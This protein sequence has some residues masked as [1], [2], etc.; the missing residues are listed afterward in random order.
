MKPNPDY[1]RQLHSLLKPAC[2][3]AYPPCDGSLVM[4]LIRGILS[5][6]TSDRNRDM[7]F[8][9]LK[10]AYPTPQKLVQATAE[11]IEKLIS[12]AGLAPTKSRRIYNLLRQVDDKRLSLL[13]YMPP[14][15]AMEYL[16]SLDGIGIKTAAV[17]LLFNFS[18]PFFPVDTHIDRVTR[19]LGIVRKGVGRKR[20]QELL[21]R[22]VPTELMLPLHL[23][24]IHLGRRWCK[25]RR[26]L[27]ETCPVSK[28]CESSQ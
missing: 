12:P 4:S 27:C 24:L 22:L 19:R 8:E 1:F 2:P 7:A 13:R 6:N 14:E 11:E 26:P 20:V 18:H 10:E 21:T 23:E 15:K 9:K 16:V 17:F 28:I 25:A 5:Q 3:I